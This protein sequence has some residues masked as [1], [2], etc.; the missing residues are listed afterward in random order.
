M[1]TQVGYLLY[2]TGRD[3]YWFASEYTFKENGSVLRERRYNNNSKAVVVDD[4]YVDNYFTLSK[5]NEWYGDK[6][7]APH[8]ALRSPFGSMEPTSHWRRVAKCQFLK[9][10]R[11]KG[12]KV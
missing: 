9:F 5:L 6:P 12:V 7:G 3:N 11:S 8:S 1:K 10:L 2:I 4:D